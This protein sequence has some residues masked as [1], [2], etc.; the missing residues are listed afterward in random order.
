MS[1]SQFRFTPQQGWSCRTLPNGDV[2]FESSD[3]VENF[4][5]GSSFSLVP[6]VYRLFVTCFE[7][8]F[9]SVVRSHVNGSS[10]RLSKTT[11]LSDGRNGYLVECDSHDSFELL[12]NLQNDDI[13]VARYNGRYDPESI[14][15]RQAARESAEHADSH[16]VQS[17]ARQTRPVTDRS[18][19]G[20]SS[21]RQYQPRSD[22][23]GASRQS[24]S[25]SE[26][27]G[28]WTKVQGRSQT[29][30]DRKAKN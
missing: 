26:N 4:D 25:R 29:K 30:N 28:A 9:D 14:Q 5:F 1:K 23:A 19:A 16:Q 27:T 10:V 24:Q 11:P 8:N 6:H 15:A 12:R 18:R 20:Q 22:N 2:L 13:R 17:S 21:S 7:S 3:S